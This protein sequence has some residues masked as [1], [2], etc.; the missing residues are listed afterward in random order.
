MLDG[1]TAMDPGVNRAA[2]KVSIEAIQEVK[3][4]T[5]GYQAEYGRSSGLQINAVTKSG[6]NRFHGSLYDAERK[7]VD[8]REEPRSRSCSTRR[9]TTVDQRD[10]GFT[11]G[12]PVGKPGGDNKLFFFFNYERNPRT[13]SADIINYR[14]PTLLE[15]KGDFSQTTDNDGN[16]YPYIKDPLMAGQLQCGEPGG[17]LRGRRRARPDPAESAV[18][19]GLNYPEL[20][21]GTQPWPSLPGRPTTSR[22]IRTEVALLGY[23][24][25]VRG[26]WQPTPNL[27]VT[28]KYFMYQQ[29]NTP[30]RGTIP[31]LERHA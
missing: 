6:T 9:R 31:R 27:R 11:I 5:S 22:P 10:W 12:G 25:V 14:M 18:S 30:I 26:D 20:V 19:A 8:E 23:Q 13:R 29:P 1:N 24:P 16:P 21:P 4:A 3:V 2:G 17:V 28:F 7:T 15:R